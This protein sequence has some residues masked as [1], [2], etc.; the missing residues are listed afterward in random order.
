MCSF[1]GVILKNTTLL[2]T[3]VSIVLVVFLYFTYT[4]QK[5]IVVIA[6]KTKTTIEPG[7]FISILVAFPFYPILY[8]YTKK[9][10]SELNVQKL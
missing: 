3:L 10:L 2:L 9:V 8:F 6:S 1:C 7:L 4:A 5:N